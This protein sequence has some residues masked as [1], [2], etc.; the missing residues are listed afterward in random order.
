MKQLIP[1]KLRPASLSLILTLMCLALALVSTGCR[2]FSGPNSASFASE[3]I[4]NHSGEEIANA[5]SKVFAEN[6]YKGGMTGQGEMTFEKEASRATTV[7]REGL[8][9]TYYGEQSLNRVRVELIDM[10]N[11]TVRLQ[12][13]A[14]KVSGGSDPFFQDEVPIGN[15]GAGPY[16]AML[17]KVTEQLK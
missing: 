11:D 8:I 2:S 10:G 17:K 1:I 14:Y 5:T 7:A 15:T 6:G 4:K 9:N 3:I 12:C 16:R 13:K